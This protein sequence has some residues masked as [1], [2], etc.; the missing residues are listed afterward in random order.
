MVAAALA[1][2]GCSD[3][4]TTSVT[5]PNPVELKPTGIIQGRLL[6]NVTLE[7]IQGA[8]I[9]VGTGQAT[10]NS[11]GQFAIFNVPATTQ[12]C[13]CVDDHYHFTIDLTN[14]TNDGPYPDY[15]Y[16]SVSVVFSTFDESGD[17]GSWGSFI[18]DLTSGFPDISLS[19]DISNGSNHDTP[20]TN[21]VSSVDLMV[22]KLTAC[23]SGV[24]AGCSGGDAESPV[25]AGFTVNLRT[26]G[27][28]GGPHA[29]EPNSA[30]GNV[31]RLID[32]TTT[33]SDGTFEFCN[34][35]T[36]QWWNLEASGAGMA[37]DSEVK[38]LSDG[39]T[40]VLTI[41]ESTAIHICPTDSHGPCIV[42]VSPEPGS[43]VAA[44][45]T[46]VVITWNES[47]A[48]NV[49]TDT[50][51]PPINN[52][53]DNIEVVFSG[54]K[55]GNIPYSLAW[56]DTANG[57]FTSLTASFETGESGL[58]Y[59][60]LQDIGPKLRDAAG[61]YTQMCACPDDSDASNAGWDLIDVG[62]GADD[63]GHSG[64]DDCT[65]YFSTAGTSCEL[66][67]PDV[68]LTN[69]DFLDQSEGGSDSSTEMLM[70]WAP[71][72]CAKSYNL[73]CARFEVF[74]DLSVQDTP[75]LL[76][77]GP[78]IQSEAT[79][80][81]EAAGSYVEG[82]IGAIALKYECCV[83]GVNR[84]GVESECSN[85][86]TGN[87][88]VDPALQSDGNS[89]GLC[90]G[91]GHPDV[92]CDATPEITALRLHWPEILNEENSENPANYTI[93]LTS[94]SSSVATAVH[95]P[96]NGPSDHSSNT[97]LTLATPVDPVNWAHGTIDTGPDGIADTSRC[98]DDVRVIYPG[99]GEP[100]IVCV[101]P[102]GDTTLDSTPGGDDTVS[103]ETILDGDDGICD[104]TAS[105][106]DG[107]PIAVG[108]G[109][110]NA[111]A[112]TDGTDCELEACTEG[113]LNSD[114]FGDQDDNLNPAGPAV[115]VSP[116]VTDVA[117]NNVDSDFDTLN[118]DGEAGP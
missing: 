68:V 72:A 88:V 89:N 60:R 81:T 97:V 36:W 50:T 25:G 67:T 107:Q 65:V 22:G 52:L 98:S 76:V 77:E 73:Y 92:T 116:A 6:D 20:I 32:T 53:Y 82:H 84:D 12:P 11:R 94:G 114:S 74:S 66:E 71:S 109:N 8:V 24:V 48:Q 54:T 55:A 70:D 40:T 14:V 63:S 110:P 113:N 85:T 106:D 108:S 30:T 33:A 75:M 62:L 56:G 100:N 35:E 3:D 58:Y 69:D 87:D 45:A 38:T 37:G 9:D 59:V 51:V 7:P 17:F 4:T 13:G 2:T 105:D 83:T 93:V 16:E 86:V 26:L 1:L 79:F 5:N 34:L 31:A 95:S 111:T 115:I 104:S 28:V 47:I 10:T 99:S 18:T 15:A 64:N 44:G 39:E 43:D 41:E 112:I 118:S 80:E 19:L 102:G 61:N 117:G 101:T 21:L 91:I 23:I 96:D 29:G 46:D 78:F 42:S 57:T 90:C 103:G 27:A 49:S